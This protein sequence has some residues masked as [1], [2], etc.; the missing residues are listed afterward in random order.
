MV[1]VFLANGFEEIEA[2]TPVDILRRGGIE[3]VTVGVDG[4]NVT[5]SHKIPVTADIADTDIGNFDGVEAIVL[6][7][8]MPGTL[9][10]EQNGTVQKAIAHCV[11]HNIL[12]GAI[13]AAP[14]IL[15]HLGL[16]EGKKATAYPGFEKDLKGAELG[17]FVEQDGQIVTARGMGVSTEFA[18]KLLANLKS[19]E[20]SKKV[21]DSIQC[22]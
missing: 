8:G 20:E 13:C 15:G 17:D 14:S 22:R 19:E 3:V 11:N 21:R 7:G 9:N 4:K 12:I 16:L 18:L 10:L 1:Y 6:P 5:S 2:L